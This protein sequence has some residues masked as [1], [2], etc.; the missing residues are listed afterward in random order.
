LTKGDVSIKVN[1][2]TSFELLI[3]KDTAVE[4][5]MYTRIEGKDTVY[6]ASKDLRDEA[7]KGSKDGR[8]RRLSDLT[9]TQ[10]NKV[11]VKTEKGE[12]EAEKISNHWSLTRPFK[13]RADDEKVTDLISNAT[14]PR[15]EDFVAD[16]KDPGAFGL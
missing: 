7:S 4:G 3:G 12:V 5:K 9:A 10:V 1:G 2:K 16:S 14:T 11:I 15:I 13:G 8:D 6:V